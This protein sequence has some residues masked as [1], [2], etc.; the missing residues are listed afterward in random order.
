VTD[1]QHQTGY[2]RQFETD[3]FIIVIIRCHLCGAFIKAETQAKKVESK[4][5]E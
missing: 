1:C 3:R 2:K 4:E 5:I